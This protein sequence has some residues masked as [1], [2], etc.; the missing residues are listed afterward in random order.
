MN[1]TAKQKR[2]AERNQK[3]TAEYWKLREKKIDEARLYTH[4][5]ILVMLSQKFYLA[6]ATIEKIVYNN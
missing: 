6:A 4:D 1:K 3:I 5:A 2:L